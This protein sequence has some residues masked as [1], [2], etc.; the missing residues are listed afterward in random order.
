[1]SDMCNIC[2]MTLDFPLNVFPLFFGSAILAN[3]GSP[4]VVRGLSN[5]VAHTH[6]I[7]MVSIS[8]D[9]AESMDCTI[10]VV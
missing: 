10:Y 8:A 6:N 5:N 7:Q 4:T 2:L 9:N 1:M 3:I